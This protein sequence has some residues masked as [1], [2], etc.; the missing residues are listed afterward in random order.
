MVNYVEE[1]YIMCH[2]QYTINLLG[3][4]VVI[5]YYEPY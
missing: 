2:P 1:K 3:F 5:T 4:N